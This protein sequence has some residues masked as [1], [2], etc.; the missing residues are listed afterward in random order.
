MAMDDKTK[1]L[2]PLEQDLWKNLFPSLES[3]RRIDP[4]TSSS[5]PVDWYAMGKEAGESGVDSKTVQTAVENYYK[6]LSS[7]DKAKRGKT[8]RSAQR[9]KARWERMN[10]NSLLADEQSEVKRLREE[11]DE[12]NAKS[13]ISVLLNEVSSVDTKLNACD[14]RLDS[15]SRE[16]AAA[17]I[18]GQAAMSNAAYLRRLKRVISITAAGDAAITIFLTS[19]Y[20]TVGSFDTLVDAYGKGNYAEL[21][22]RSA[23]LLLLSCIPYV[24]SI[25]VKGMVDYDKTGAARKKIEWT[26]VVLGGLFFGGA[27]L[28]YLFDALSKPPLGWSIVTSLSTLFST[29]SI[30]GLTTGLVVV[31]GLAAHHY[32]NGIQQAN[33]ATAESNVITQKLLE[34]REQIAKKQSLLRE[35][36]NELLIEIR[37]KR[38]ELLDAVRKLREARARIETQRSAAYAAVAEGQPQLDIEEVQT[39]SAAMALLGWLVGVSSRV[40]TYNPDQL[41]DYDRKRSVVERKIAGGNGH[42]HK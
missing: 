32:F 3:G 39:G 1:T 2:D 21:V 12:K 16:E 35:R 29:T 6:A 37:K 18:K 15:I 42:S 34:Q 17:A 22:I 26:S 24:L 7:A 31:G 11:V 19:D 40:K 20:L 38:A 9:E 33:I 8:N 30:F 5:G 13:P 28:S 14:S 25:A 41:A 36:R 23:G 4:K 10:Q 27:A